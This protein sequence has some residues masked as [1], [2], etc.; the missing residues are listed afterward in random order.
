M[1]VIVPIVN[2]SAN[3]TFTNLIDTVNLLANVVSNYVLTVNTLAN[4][5]LTTGNGFVNGMFGANTLFATNIRG[6]NVQTSGNISF[7]SNVSFSNIA[8]F[9]STLLL[10][11]TST[12]NATVLS[13]GNSTVNAVLNA[14]SLSFNNVAIINANT[15]E[16]VFQNGS[17]IG[18]RGSLNFIG[19][20]GLTVACADNA[21]TN[22]IDITLSVSANG[23]I[24]GANTYVQFNDQGAIGATAGLVFN[25]TSNTF[26][27]GNV[28]NTKLISYQNIFKQ[29]YEILQANS[30][31]FEMDSFLKSDFIGG[32]YV[33]STKDNVN[34]D[35]QISKV[36][37]IHNGTTA[38]LTEYSDVNTGKD[39]VTFY[40]STNTTHVILN[41]NVLASNTSS[42][43]LKTMIS[44]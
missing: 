17:A 41:A 10:G 9:S 36:I 43:L 33:I 38:T 35:I 31:S 28:V 1:S 6:G 2:V 29:S 39:L 4:G 12:L 3:A 8:S 13:I 19:A 11:N 42:K 16:S 44:V 37:I 24:A 30:V 15:R 21:N 34:S 26:T 32:E 5:S 14:T 27:V 23:I 22:A 40:P 25:K 20:G 7:I 18:V